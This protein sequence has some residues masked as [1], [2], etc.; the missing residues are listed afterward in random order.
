MSHRETSQGMR[1]QL[2]LSRFSSLGGSSEAR[3]GGRG[4]KVG[5]EVGVALARNANGLEIKNAKKKFFFRLTR[6]LFS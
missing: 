4:R 2:L 6:K 1:W 3:G 5:E